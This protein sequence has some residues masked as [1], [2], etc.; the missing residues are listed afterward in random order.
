[1]NNELYIG[2][3]IWNRLRYVKDP[4]TGKRVSRLNDQSGWVI[5]EAPEL[6]IMPQD[7]W[8][9]AKARQVAMA[10]DKGTNSKL[11]PLSHGGNRGSNPLGDAKYFNYLGKFLS[12]HLCGTAKIRQRCLR[13]ATTFNSCPRETSLSCACGASVSF[14]RPINCCRLDRP[15]EC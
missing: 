15:G 4:S 2:R 10:A 8:D 12:A 14:F 6:R 11:S 1:L 3:L 9:L 7:L 13:K 5:H